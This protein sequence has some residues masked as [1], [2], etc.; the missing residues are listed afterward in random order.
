MEEFRELSQFALNLRWFLK[1][2]GLPPEKWPSALLQ[3]T[4][5]TISNSRAIGLLRGADPTEG[6]VRV[7]LDVMGCDREELFTVPFYTHDRSLLSLNLCHLVESIPHGEGK[8]AA[9]K[10]GVSEGQLSRWKKWT[11]PTP[12]YP[13]NLRNLL[14]FHGMDPDIDLEK[15]P[16]FLSMEP[17][18]GYSQKEWLSSRVQEMPASEVAKLYPALRKLL[19]D[20]EA[21]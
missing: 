3:R 19:R 9:G 5:K 15:V 6:E 12:P 16:L 11:K 7:L 18:S 21:N 10:I 4:R 14:K 8:V 20:D 13:A 1:G 2:A 17:I